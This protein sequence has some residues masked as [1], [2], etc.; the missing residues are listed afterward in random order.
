MSMSKLVAN[1]PARLS[2]RLWFGWGDV[3]RP[4]RPCRLARF[5]YGWVVGGGTAEGGGVN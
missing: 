2:G 5:F 1:A 3:W 4:S